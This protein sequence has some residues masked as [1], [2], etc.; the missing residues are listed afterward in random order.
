MSDKTK[1]PQP[2]PA[3]K[4]DPDG[5][6]PLVSGE[7]GPK[8]PKM[9]AEKPLHP[10]DAFNKRKET[11]NG[12]TL[13]CIKATGRDFIKVARVM[14][15]EEEQYWPAVMHVVLRVGGKQLAPAQYEQLEWR[16]FT[17]LLEELI[18]MGF[19]PAG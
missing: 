7:I 19:S 13:S 4:S 6:A 14:G 15:G 11:L 9:T 3:V 8:G 10:I 17:G 1:N 5:L 18:A 12:E 2:T 16:E